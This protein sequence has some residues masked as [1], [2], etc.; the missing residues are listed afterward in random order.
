MISFLATS[1]PSSLAE[2]LVIAFAAIGGI[3][4]F[5]GL[6][7]EKIAEWKSE[8]HIVKP[9]KRLSEWGWWILM[10]GIAVEIGVAVWSANDAWQTRQ[11]AN[12]NNPLNQR[13][14]DVSADASI[15]VRGGNLNDELDFR[16]HFMVSLAGI[17]YLCDSNRPSTNSWPT[18]SSGDFSRMF[19]DNPTFLN[20]MDR[21]YGI[22]FQKEAAFGTSGTETAKAKDINGIFMV[23]MDVFFLPTNSVILGGSVVLTINSDVQKVFQIPAQPKPE[24]FNNVEKN[25]PTSEDFGIVIYATNSA[26]AY[27]IPNLKN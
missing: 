3:I 24:P 13:V 8:K 1:S 21:R 2:V 18:L 10:A 17:M 23:S 22:R 14:A 6:L 26:P 27:V 11:I 15:I 5:A 12:S 19:F 25:I 16:K 20:K 9:F 7:L 4:V